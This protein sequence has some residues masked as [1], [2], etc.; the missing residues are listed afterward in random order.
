MLKNSIREYTI[1][2]RDP[3]TAWSVHHSG[4]TGSGAWI[5][6]R[7]IDDWL[8]TPS[9]LI[10]HYV[11][12]P[13]FVNCGTR[14]KPQIQKSQYKMFPSISQLSQ[15][16]WKTTTIH[17]HSTSV[18]IVTL[19]SS[20]SHQSYHTWS[21]MVW[22][23]YTVLSRTLLSHNGHLSTFS[24]LS[25][26]GDPRSLKL[27]Y[28]LFFMPSVSASPEILTLDSPFILSQTITQP[29]RI[30]ANPGRDAKVYTGAISRKRPRSE[31]GAFEK[32][33]IKRERN[34]IDDQGENFMKR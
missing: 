4:P 24:C 23:I 32:Q 7:N 13:N 27:N 1:V 2:P 15:S 33:N 20:L 14:T 6:D 31:S 12:G 25:K 8:L 22:L 11:L 19:G 17:L 26:V 18:F 21:Y 3:R 10:I 9:N 16:I 34:S 29:I 30:T 5:P 28:F